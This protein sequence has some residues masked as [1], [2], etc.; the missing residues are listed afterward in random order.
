MLIEL[1]F[2]NDVKHTF[3][4]EHCRF[5]DEWDLD[6]EH[7]IRSIIGKERNYTI[8]P[9]IIDM[10][11]PNVESFVESEFDS[12]DAETAIKSLNH[13]CKWSEEDLCAFEAYIQDTDD[14]TVMLENKPLE[15]LWAGY[16]DNRQDAIGEYFEFADLTVWDYKADYLNLE[17]A[18]DELCERL[19]ISMYKGL[20]IQGF[21][22]TEPDYGNTPTNEFE[23]D[24][25][26]TDQYK[27][28]FNVKLIGDEFIVKAKNAKVKDLEEQIEVAL[29]S[30]QSDF[31]ISNFKSN[32]K[33]TG[34]SKLEDI[35]FLMHNL[36]AYVFNYSYAFVCAVIQ[37]TG[38]NRFNR[39]DFE[40]AF[41][42]AR[43]NN[44]S[45]NIRDAEQLY[46][47]YADDTFEFSGSCYDW[48][49]FEKDNTADLAIG[50]C[51]ENNMWYV[52]QM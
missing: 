31:K 4:T 25:V 6:W 33:L 46:N 15:Y 26:L 41:E 5:D 1:L 10:D 19:D 42:A 21:Y 18:A 12:I 43:N 27:N 48:K 36:K 22:G 13:L 37:G 14:A 49:Q 52:F 17:D 39:D 38:S 51:E 3:D 32:T 9:K 11:L 47:T 28:Q 34:I 29:T 30:G 45:A 44:V 50:Y 40:Y 35:Q 16:A 23:C 7:E 24:F 2:N 20:A 8:I